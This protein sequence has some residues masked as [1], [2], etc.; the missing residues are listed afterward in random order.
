MYFDW[1]QTLKTQCRF[2]SVKKSRRARTRIGVS[3]A[4]EQRVMLTTNV[5]LVG[6]DLEIRD[7][8][9]A[10]EANDLTL[11]VSGGSLVISEST[12]QIDVTGIAGA[13]G[14]GTNA[15][16]IPLTAFTG[17]VVVNALGGDDTIDISAL[18]SNLPGGLIIDAGLGLDTVN[19]NGTLSLRSDES[20]NIQADTINLTG[21]TSDVS[22]SGIGTINLTADRNIELSVDSSLSTVNGGITLNANP[23]GTTAGTFVGLKTD[24]ASIRTSGTG[25]ILLTGKGG[26]DSLSQ[27]L[28]GIHL[29]NTSVQSLSN[30]ATAGTITIDG[31]GGDGT[32]SNNGIVLS[33]FNTAVTSFKGDI[34][35]VGQ[36]GNGT[37]SSNFGIQ[38]GF[39]DEIS[40]RGT[41][42]DAA[43]ISILG[44]GGTGKYDSLGI[45]M[46]GSNSEVKSIDGDIAI[47]G[48][49]GNDSQ[50]SHIGMFIFNSMKIRSTG[51]GP[52]AAD[53]TLTG[54]GGTSPFGGLGLF[55]RGP[56]MEISSSAGDITLV[57]QGGTATNGS[58][59]ST[60]LFMQSSPTARVGTGQLSI[61]GTGTGNFGPGISDQNG[62]QLLS[63]GAGSIEITGVGSGTNFSIGDAALIGGPTATGPITINADT[64]SWA[65]TTQIQ[66][67]GA[68]TIQPRTA[69]TTIGLGG[70]TGTLNLTDSDL[71]TLVDGF[72]SITVGNATSGDVT[73]DTA[74]FNDALHLVTG[75]EI[76]D[77]AGVDL[78]LAVGDS[79]TLNGTVAPGLSPGALTVTGDVVLNNGDV[80]AI[81]ID[82]TAGVGLAGGHDQIIA[83]GRVDLV[84]TV[85][86][87]L[88][89]TYTPVGGE[90]FTIIERTGGTG[91]F[92]GLP[93]GTIL[94]NFLGTALDATITYTGGDGDDV[95]LSVI[96]PPETRISVLGNDLVI[97]DVNGGV[98][99]D[100]LNFSVSGTN[101]VIND[102]ANE[103]EVIG[104]AGATGNETHKVTLPLSAFTGNVIVNTYGGDDTVD[105]STLGNRLPAGLFIDTGTGLDSVDLNGTINLGSG[106][107]DVHA[108]TITLTSSAS[109][110]FTS[111][112]GSINLSADRNIALNSGSSLTT[113]DGG[114]TLTAN[115]SGTS[116]GSFSGVSATSAFLRT[117]GTG[118]IVVLGKGSDDATTGSHFGI[119]LNN[120]SIISSAIGL[121]AGTILLDGEGGAGTTS[122]V[123]VFLQGTSNRVSSVDGDIDIRGQG[124]NGTQGSNIGVNAFFIRDITS[125][126]T[127][128]DA[129]NITITGTGGAGTAGNSG[130]IL[131]GS[132][133]DVTS[134]DGDITIVGQGGVGTSSTNFGVFVDQIDTI[135]S[136][137][138]GMDAAT[139][140]IEGTGGAGSAS[141]YGLLIQGAN[142]TIVGNNGDVTLSGRGGSG[143]SSSSHGLLLKQGPTVQN[144]AGNL[145]VLGV[146][147]GTNSIGISADNGSAVQS[148]GSGEIEITAEGTLTDFVTNGSVV[149]GGPSTGPLAITANTVDWST[150]TQLQST[151]SLTIQP[152]TAGTSIGLG[153]GSGTLNLSDTELNSLVD[154][155]SSVTIGNATSGDIDIDTAAFADST[156]LVTGGTIQDRSGNDLTLTAGDAVTLDGDVTPGVLTVTG[157]AVLSDTVEIEIGG[158][159]PGEGVGFH[160]QINVSGSV[161]IGPNVALSVN[162]VSYTPTASDELVTIDSGSGVSGTFN[163]LPEGSLLP[164]FLNSG[165]DFRITYVGGVD[166]HDVVL[167]R[168]NSA[169]IAT[170]DADLTE[171]D[172]VLSGVSVLANDTD[173]ENDPLVVIALNGNSANIGQ[174]TVLASGATVTLHADGSFVYDP[175]TSTTF[176][177]LPFGQSTV[178][179]FGYSI[180]DGNG[181][182]DTATVTITVV[183]VNDAPTV[184][185]AGDVVVDEGQTATNSGTWSDVDASNSV[186]LTASVGT[187]VKNANG[188][189]N[190]SFDTNDGPDQ[191][192]NVVI[193][194]NDSSG[195]TTQTD[196]VLTVANVAPTFVSV[197]PDQAIDEGQLLSLT[198]LATDPGA[199]LLTYSWNFGDGT[200]AVGSAVSHAYADNGIYTVALTVTDPDGGS[201]SHSFN[202]TV[203]N[204]APTTVLAGPNV[205]VRNHSVTWSGTFTDPGSADT[206]QQSWVITNSLGTIVTTGTGSSLDY[207][208]S[209]LGT[210]TVQYTVNDDDGGSHS[211]NLTFDV[212][213]AAVIPTPN[214][215]NESLLVIGG[216]DLA[217]KISVRP[218]SGGGIRVDVRERHSS[219]A[220][221][222]RN[223]VFA[224]AVSEVLIYAGGGNDMVQIHSQLPLGTTIYG[225][226]GADL[227]FGGSQADTIFGEAGDDYLF[228]RGG[229]DHIDSGDGNDKIWGNAGNDVI[230]GGSGDDRISSGLGDDV[231]YGNAG[232]DWIW[233]QNGSDQLYGNEGRDI[234]LGGNGDDLIWGEAHDDKLYG[235]AGNDQI[236]GGDGNDVISGGSGNDTLSGGSGDDVLY[237]EAGNDMLIGDDGNDVLFGGSGHD[238]LDGGDGS[239]VLFGGPG[240]D[241]LI[242][243]HFDA[244]FTHWH[245]FC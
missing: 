62:A 179:S 107:L 140:T 13:T 66:S 131:R 241:Q 230:L 225:G 137:G 236:W 85:N 116:V 20:L 168:A 44:T 186:T 190:W 6:S 194:A 70:G 228:G 171:E 19:L 81:E 235:Q 14:S 79:V 12:N 94:T 120:S 33:G 59:S 102:P 49:G 98:S 30:S 27:D 34:Q 185:N 232:D 93:E 208:P 244:V 205:A 92:D 136:T 173:A 134:V 96:P 127:G 183:G 29:V 99:N 174:A 203:A 87:A 106:N 17:D 139:I 152:R 69:G 155:F 8:S 83:T 90:S 3:E 222:I 234:V 195:V 22:T 84:G 7:G 42:P 72:S 113:V 88:S 68:L 219:G 175:T 164:N 176:D 181:L 75:G 43:R 9:S 165:T 132:S 25:N 37:E 114:I 123:G 130:V 48:Q 245:F 187:V 240:H 24:S 160:D 40:S 65:A 46:S 76:H 121:S 129:A 97:E 126:G 55:L 226:N 151:G 32:R 148:V 188:T 101:L 41:G 108:D 201:D 189:W 239:D 141:N 166:G 95:V 67:S 138:A 100:R 231:V 133:T 216:S 197:P 147:T 74:T 156:T 142:T 177:S 218:Q 144:N 35:I 5:A 217:E 10:G 86:L 215:P 161:T 64:L 198:A 78:T 170:D 149:V 150:G 110:I 209:D 237:G 162:S 180:T 52:D 91:T 56:S 172:T 63:T 111:G 51:T 119:H 223:L 238:T 158:S 58:S 227:I 117:S 122:N 157:H 38:L 73:I 39:I 153:G 214:N 4:L 163:G 103:L 128:A 200:T 154:G 57:G 206:H 21:S 109:D 207:T 178:D 60:G 118:D 36:G 15:V 196:F 210:F 82:G 115:S 169:P 229:N 80:L 192:Q 243:D 143:L 182:F 221:T 212:F 71:A 112:S 89:G 220:E 146:G 16:T 224:E 233:G 145:S 28:Y 53:I 199:E 124:G 125:T 242:T 47:T 211:S 184:T 61:Q 213:A 105:V 191:S 1:L 202:V 11:S 2:R 159:T 167:H 50:S 204:V 193:T 135:A 23:T 45:M 18:G 31:E 77:H 54:T 104:I 26:D